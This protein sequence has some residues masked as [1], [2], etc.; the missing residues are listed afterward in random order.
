MNA[1]LFHRVLSKEEEGRRIEN[2]STKVTFIQ[3]QF[4]EKKN[5]NLHTSM[6]AFSL[7]P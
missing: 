3:D 2:M 5:M 7:Q 1:K 6:A 4:A